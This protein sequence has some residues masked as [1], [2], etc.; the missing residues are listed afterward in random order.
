MTADTER[1]CP[2]CDAMERAREAGL[3]LCG[4]CEQ[5]YTLRCPRGH[6]YC[7]CGDLMQPYDGSD[8]T[9]CFRCATDL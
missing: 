2:S 6:H 1:T 5:P 8:P 7:D 3:L 9:H 4:W